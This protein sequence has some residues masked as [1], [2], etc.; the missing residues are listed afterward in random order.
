MGLE[1]LPKIYTH[2]SLSSGR[3]VA[4]L[5]HFGRVVG[6]AKVFPGL[7]TRVDGRQGQRFEALSIKSRCSQ[8]ILTN[9]LQYAKAI[10]EVAVIQKMSLDTYRCNT[11]FEIIV[12]VTFAV[13]CV[14]ESVGHEILQFCQ[15][16]AVC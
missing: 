5:V 13:E 7:L 16:L 14:T 3:R 15:V 9:S 4:T 2:V 10:I 6:L 11:L 8:L 12:R 1:Q